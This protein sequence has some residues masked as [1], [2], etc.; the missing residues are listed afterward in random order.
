MS[1]FAFLGTCQ[2][3]VP[4]GCK[5]L[6][7]DTCIDLALSLHCLETVITFQPKASI[8][9]RDMLEIIS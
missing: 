8:S 6:L 5:F 4:L 3:A 7:L 2:N 9:D 1:S